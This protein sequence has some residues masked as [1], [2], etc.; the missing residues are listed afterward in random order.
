MKACA[1]WAASVG[2]L[3]ILLLL[4]ASRWL[5]PSALSGPAAEGGWTNRTRA[6]FTIMGV[7]GVETDPT[8][9]RPFSWTGPSAR[10]RFPEL[11]TDA[12]YIVS[13]TI[14]S[15]RPPG[16]A[17]P[18]FVVRR[19]GANVAN[20]SVNAI[21][22]QVKVTLPEARSRS[23]L[24]LETT[25]IYRVEGLK[26]RG[27]IIDAIELAPVAGRFEPTWSALLQAGSAC[28][29]MMLGVVLAG[30]RGRLAA[31]LAVAILTG[32]TWLL[33]QDGAFLGGYTTP[34]MWI[35]LGAAAAGGLTAI[36]RCR[37]PVIGL[38]PEWWLAV[39]IVIGLSALKLGIFWHPL[40]I[41]GDGIFQ[42]H[43]AQMVHRG[44]YFF[45]SVTPRPFFEFPYAIALYVA[46]QP[47]W[48]TLP[49]E[50]DLLHLLRTLCV[51]VDGCVGVA[52]FGAVRRQSGS[53]FAALLAAALWPL[54]R[55]PFEALSNANLTNLF[56]QAAF[57]AGLAGFAWWGAG[58]ART[59]T[60]LIPTG[61]LITIGFLSHFGTST[62]GV[63]V[64]GVSAVL[65]MVAGTGA[66]RSAG[67]W[68]LAM[69]IAVTAISWVAY[70]SHFT[71]VFANTY[72]QLQVG[73]QDDTSKVVA[74]PGVKFAR[75]RSGMGDDYGLPGWPALILACAGLGL[76]IWRRQRDAVSVVFSAWLLAWIGLSALGIFTPLTL[77]ANLAAAPAFV[78]LGACALASLS[79]RSRSGRL[80][81]LAIAAVVGWN[82]LQVGLACLTTSW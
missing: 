43:R 73:E 6:A 55:A 13:F 81:A 30:V 65:L 82:G 16:T 64:L 9:G 77:R 4:G 14:R 59:K 37:W 80:A 17:D 75:W 8:S 33:I 53:R 61:A 1:G 36:T 39:G 20:V 50:M 31:G 23:L 28:A 29:G 46:A 44:E 57:G 15:G 62:V 72:H 11:P 67:A 27:V 19:D 41:V 3:G 34:L 66:A 38:V 2:I 24:L 54:A 79:D 45:T 48:G 76:V 71:S 47:F 51:V 42:V 5:M 26:D 63:I 56:G 69:T 25:P 21:P 22:Q 52:V 12:A 70:Y 7:Q 18:A 40:A 60:M 58:G 49:S 74:S 35:G 32:T 78:G 68:L 10:I